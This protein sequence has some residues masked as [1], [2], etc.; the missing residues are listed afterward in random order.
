MMK[1]C[2]EMKAMDHGEY[3]TKLAG[4]HLSIWQVK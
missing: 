4:V 3:K 1:A 2:K